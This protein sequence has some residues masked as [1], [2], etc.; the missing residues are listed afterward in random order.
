MQVNI[1]EKVH[2]D[3]TVNGVDL[4]GSYGPGPS[5]VPDEVGELL[6]A[7]GIASGDGTPAPVSRPVRD[8]DPTAKQ[9]R[10]RLEAL[11]L[12]THGNKATLA[13]RLAAAE[14]DADAPAP[15]AATDSPDDG[16][17]GEDNTDDPSA[18]PSTENPEA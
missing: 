10:E 6:I 3:L 13:E 18:S 2:V 5:E 12:D 9:L 17:P 1:S 16:E 4:S 8:G 14:S 7:Q 11:G 15:E